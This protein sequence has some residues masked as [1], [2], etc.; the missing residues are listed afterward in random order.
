MERNYILQ[1]DIQFCENAL[2]FM[3]NLLF[4]IVFIKVRYRKQHLFQKCTELH[5]QI[6]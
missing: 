2:P 4:I 6:L 5:P 3:V 1:A